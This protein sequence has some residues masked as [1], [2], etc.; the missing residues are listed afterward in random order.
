M[1]GLAL[2]VAS[3]GRWAGSSM[4]REDLGLMLF[5]TVVK[6]MSGLNGVVRSC[7]L[8]FGVLQREYRRA[9]AYSGRVSLYCC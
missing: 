9:K 7:F 4:D 3:A 8:F 5:V 2:Y 6:E 1:L